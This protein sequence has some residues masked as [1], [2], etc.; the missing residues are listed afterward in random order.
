MSLNGTDAEKPSLKLTLDVSSVG[1]DWQPLLNLISNLPS[2]K[3]VSEHC[4]FAFKN[5]LW[6]VEPA[7]D[8]EVEP[9]NHPLDCRMAKIV[10]QSVEYRK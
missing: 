4:P 1:D 10:Y 2:P 3:T 5:S 7:E 9:N 6:P 8:G